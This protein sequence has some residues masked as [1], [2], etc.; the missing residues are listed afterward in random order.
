MLVFAAFMPHTPLLVESVGKDNRKKLKKTLQALHKLEE[1]LAR[2]APET[3]VIIS[4]HPTTHATAFSINLHDPYRADLSRFGDLGTD[5]TFA[6]D[7]RLIDG[8]QRSLRRAGMPVTLDTDHALDHGA[9][10]PLLTLFADRPAPHVVAVT[11]SELGPKE[12]AA[13]GRALREAIEASNRRIAVIA[14]GDLSHAL[15]KKSPVEPRPEGKAFDDA[16]CQSVYTVSLSQLLNLEPALVEA[17][18][19]CAYR[20]LL[21]LFGLLEKV[22]VKPKVLAYEAPFG[23]GYLTA[24]FVL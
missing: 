21:M 6:P 15:N 8:L 10:V 1:G 16:V 4:A 7:L 24:E 11:Y 17:A 22:A 20:P 23:V 5:R 18:A 9:T 13:F 2:A 3:V 19:E 14:S 12:H